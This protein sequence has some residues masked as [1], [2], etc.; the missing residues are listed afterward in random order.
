MIGMEG[1]YDDFHFLHDDLGGYAWIILLREIKIATKN[2]YQI[3]HN[4]THDLIIRQVQVLYVMKLRC[5]GDALA[6]HEWNLIYS[7]AGISL[8]CEQML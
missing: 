4:C 6:E 1:E 3:M 5:G 2:T 8:C 7:G